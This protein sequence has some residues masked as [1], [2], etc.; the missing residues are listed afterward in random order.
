MKSKIP[1][2]LLL[3]VLSG[4]LFPENSLKIK[5]IEFSPFIHFESRITNDIE[6]T[7]GPDYFYQNKL[8]T[9]DVSA[10]GCNIR[11]A[12][13]F[14]TANL[15]SAWHNDYSLPLYLDINLGYSL[16]KY[17]LYCG[18]IYNLISDENGTM[19]TLYLGIDKDIKMNNLLL[20]LTAQ[21]IIG[22][23]KTATGT[24]ENETETNKLDIISLNLFLSYQYAYLIPYGLF[25]GSL[26]N[27]ADDP[28][29]QLSLGISLFNPPA[30]R[31][32]IHP[33]YGTLDYVY[34]DKPNIY[35]YPEQECVVDVHI[36]PNGK[37]TK[38]IPEYGNG[39]NVTVTSQGLIDDQYNFLFYEA[40]VNV[41]TP[42]EGWCVAKADL[43][44]FFSKLLLEYGLNQTEI[45]D[46][47]E[48]WTERLTDSQYYT[49]HPL[50]NNDI[51]PVCPI[52]IDPKPDNLL[53]LWF[54]FIPQKENVKL[55]APVVSAFQRN[56]FHVVEWGGILH[57]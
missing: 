9:T 3:L 4:T 41:N 10:L 18:K 49:V 19:E 28:Q 16:H 34:V 1:I 25:S 48:Y 11:K 53:R 56:G 24:I 46:F 47:I 55:P 57:N 30:T 17:S 43:K 5:D 22:D 36:K 52:S 51:D 45:N 54:V 26:W 32:L 38:S 35:F 15:V 21:Y 44:T 14:S 6:F 12:N 7:T 13:F 8:Y 20:R 31:N 39:W 29:Y 37:I 2:I 27:I 33:A 42:E 50:I 23:Y 40:K